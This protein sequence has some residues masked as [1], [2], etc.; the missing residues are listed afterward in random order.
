MFGPDMPQEHRP[1]QP[2]LNSIADYETRLTVEDRIWLGLMDIECGVD[3]IM[4]F[5]ADAARSA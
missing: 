4:G 5:D 1:I 2:P 3:R